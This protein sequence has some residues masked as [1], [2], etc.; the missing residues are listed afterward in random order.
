MVEAAT[1]VVAREYD[2]DRDRRG[3]EAMN[4]VCEV[5]SSVGGKMCLF[6][7]LFGDPLSRIRHSP[8]FL[9][10]VRMFYVLGWVDPSLCLLSCLRSG[11]GEARQLAQLDAGG[12]PHPPAPAA[13]APDLSSRL[14][15]SR[16]G[17]VRMEKRNPTN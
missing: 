1:V 11:C 12:R 10:M 9:M 17:M 8:A 15:S 14:V 4:R 7:D 13:S 3:V 2:D 16:P 6:A 5:R